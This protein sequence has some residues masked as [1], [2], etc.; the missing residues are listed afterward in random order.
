MSKIEG[1]LEKKSL[2]R[3]ASLSQLTVSI[4]PLAK[5]CWWCGVVAE[6]DGV[7]RFGVDVWWVK[8]KAFG[9]EC[10]QALGD[11][12]N[13]ETLVGSIKSPPKGRGRDWHLGGQQLG[14]QASIVT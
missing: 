11:T 8:G 4:E 5:P 10:F 1:T 6:D 9:F 3:G 14:L 13:I 12:G 2:E 7:W